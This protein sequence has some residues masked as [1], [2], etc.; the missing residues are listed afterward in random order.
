MQTYQGEIRF[1]DYGAYYM[2]KRRKNPRDGFMPC[3]T[4]C[5]E[6]IFLRKHSR[7][8]VTAELLEWI[9]R[10]LATLKNMEWRTGA[11]TEGRELRSASGTTGSEY[12]AS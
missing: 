6:K 7:C 12:R 4:R 3:M 11:G 5:G 8:A 9:G 2:R 1:R 10:A